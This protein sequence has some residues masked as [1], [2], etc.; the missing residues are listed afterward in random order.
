MLT[1]MLRFRHFSVPSLCMR[2][3][4]RVS[5]EAQPLVFLFQILMTLLTILEFAIIGR[6]LMSWFDRTMSN[7]ISQ[8]L[9]QITEPIIAPIRRIVPSAGMLDLSPMVAILLILVLQ[10]MLSTALA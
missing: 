10:R 4:S 3:P 8:I 9:V 2:Q 6:A 5:M 1:F 7:P